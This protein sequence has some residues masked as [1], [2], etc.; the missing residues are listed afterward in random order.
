M[1]QVDHHA[2]IVGTPAQFCHA[3]D[4]SSR[5]DEE[6]KAAPGA[7]TV[8]SSVVLPRSCP[9]RGMVPPE[10]MSSAERRPLRLCTR[11][12]SAWTAEGNAAAAVASETKLVLASYLA[13]TRGG[14]G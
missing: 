8:R 6:R 12:N 10:A 4:C 5:G 3:G 7:P 1:Q 11:D 13:R 14:W 2:Q 9:L